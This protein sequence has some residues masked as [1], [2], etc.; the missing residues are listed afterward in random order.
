MANSAAKLVP[1]SLMKIK[2]FV[3]EYINKMP[4]S[5][6]ELLKIYKS[7]SLAKKALIEVGKS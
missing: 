7:K 4:E 5:E 2:P 3:D 1:I 6:V